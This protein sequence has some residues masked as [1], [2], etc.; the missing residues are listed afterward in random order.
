LLREAGGI[1]LAGLQM[2]V[3]VLFATLLTDIALGFIGKASPQLPVMLVGL[4]L[5][6][7]V[8][9]FALGGALALWP[10]LF[11][12]HFSQALAAGERLLHLAT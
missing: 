12:R 3:P 10:R 8:G 7:L 4:S 1:W 5:K 2:A 9:L 6:N 11:E